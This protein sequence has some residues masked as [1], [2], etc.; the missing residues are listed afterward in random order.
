MLTYIATKIEEDSSY[1]ESIEF[2]QLKTELALKEDSINTEYDFENLSDE[3]AY[4]V[5]Q[6]AYQQ[7]INTGGSETERLACLGLY[8][9]CLTAGGGGRLC[10]LIYD[11][12]N[13]IGPPSPNWDY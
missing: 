8:T 10:M 7:Y 13:A 5:V 1:I 4:D 6:T 12:C 2:A 9:T 11:I 3:E